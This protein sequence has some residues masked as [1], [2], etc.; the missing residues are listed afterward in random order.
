MGDVFIIS[1]VTLQSPLGL[2]LDK[3][4]RREALSQGNWK[5][6]KEIELPMTTWRFDFWSRNF[7]SGPMLQA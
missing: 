6:A 7:G 4:C 3:G 2:Y 1:L 5:V